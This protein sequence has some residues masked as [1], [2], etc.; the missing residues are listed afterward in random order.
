MKSINEY[1]NENYDASVKKSIKQIT[2]EI[3]DLEDANKIKEL[4]ELITDLLNSITN[5]GEDQT[6][7]SVITKYVE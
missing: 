4:R 3:V 1:V 2:D 6:V 7:L 5:N